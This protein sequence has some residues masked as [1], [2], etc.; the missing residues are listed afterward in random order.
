MLLIYVLILCCQYHLI[1]RRSIY[2]FMTTCLMFMWHRSS[3]HSH[4]WIIGEKQG[5]C[6]NISDMKDMLSHFHYQPVHF[7][8]REWRTSSC[9]AHFNVQLIV[10]L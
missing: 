5:K 10:C 6:L 8:I 2:V 3:L 7:F 4:T 9:Y 1:I